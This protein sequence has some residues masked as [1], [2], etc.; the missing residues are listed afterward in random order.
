MVSFP[1][2]PAVTITEAT[3]D[4]KTNKLVIKIDYTA[5]LQD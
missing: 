3:I 5:D 2:N 4:P 1:D